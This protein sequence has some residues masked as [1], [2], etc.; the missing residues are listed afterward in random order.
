VGRRSRSRAARRRS[1]SAPIPE[2]G[3]EV[4]EVE[5][6]SWRSAIERAVWIGLSEAARNNGALAEDEPD[7]LLDRTRE[8]IATGRELAPREAEERRFQRA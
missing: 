3:F 7:G 6:A 8:A 1:G 2:A 4:V 5:L